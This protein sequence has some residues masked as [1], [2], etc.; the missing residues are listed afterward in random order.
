MITNKSIP[1]SVM[2]SRPIE[3]LKESESIKVL[4][5]STEIPEFIQWTRPKAGT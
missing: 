4:L 2:R 1:V 5:E 3:I